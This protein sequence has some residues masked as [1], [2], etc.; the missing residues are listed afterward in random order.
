MCISQLRGFDLGLFSCSSEQRFAISGKIG[1]QD[2][3]PR[4]S[5]RLPAEKHVRNFMSS[6][7][8]EDGF[9]AGTPIRPGPNREA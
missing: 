5:H 8:T 2:T 6:T 1:I 4:G 7:E 3:N 9:S